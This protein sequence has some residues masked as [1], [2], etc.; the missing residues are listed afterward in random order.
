MRNKWA[1]ISLDDSK[2]GPGQS[3]AS[4]AGRWVMLVEEIAK[5]MTTKWNADSSNN[6]LEYYLHFHLTFSEL[7]PYHRWWFSLFFAAHVG[8]CLT[9]TLQVIQHGSVSTLSR[10]G[11]CSWCRTAEM[12]SSVAKEVTKLNHSLSLSLSLSFTYSLMGARE[13][14]H[15]LCLIIVPAL[16]LHPSFHQHPPLPK[17]RVF[18]FSWMYE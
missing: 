6:F 7:S 9:C 8:T 1:A 4:P 3:R 15:Q 12:S 2:W 10:N 17:T 16:C 18:I 13:R 5:W 14:A 11:S